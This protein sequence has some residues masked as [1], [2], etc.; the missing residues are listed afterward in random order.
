MKKFPFVAGAVALVLSNTLYAQYQTSQMGQ[1]NTRGKIASQHDFSSIR[2]NPASASRLL[3]MD[4]TFDFNALG[5]FGA[6]YEVGEVDDLLDELDELID[7]LEQDELSAQDALDAKE[8][9]DPFLIDAEEN[10]RVKAFGYASI[11]LFPVMIRVADNHVVY[12]DFHIGG[13]LRSTVIADEIDIVGFNDTFAIN[14]DAAV[15]VKSS[16]LISFGIGYAGEFYE[17]DFGTIHAGAKL[18]INR[19]SLSKNII[20]LAGLEDGEDIGDA[21]KDDYENNANATVNVGLDLGTELVGDNYMLGLSVTDVNEPEYDYG[22]LVSDC[23]GLS[24]LSLDNCLV[25]QNVIADG[26]IRGDE[27]YKANAQATLSASYSLGEDNGVVL[28][29][30]FD[31]NEKNDPIGDPYQWMHVSATSFFENSF[32]PELRLGY[33]QNLAGTELS[34]YAAGITLFKYADLD[35]AWSDETVDI[36]GTSAPRSLFLSLSFQASF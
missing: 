7:I 20:S 10:G 6:G 31:L 21:I 26:A 34:Y 18:N 29:A 2:L 27:T 4:N 11:P 35:I 16:G 15:Y 24:G 28:G 9:F 25:A 36:D 5:P 22:T 1:A 30:S 19:L 23:Q 17:S 8:R 12:T 3:P 32:I 14:T 33:S 13:S